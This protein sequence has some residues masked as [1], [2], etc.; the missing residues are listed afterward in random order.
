[1]QRFPKLKFFHFT[2]IRVRYLRN[3]GFEQTQDWK[4]RNVCLYGLCY[5]DGNGLSFVVYLVQDYYSGNYWNFVI[6]EFIVTDTN[7]R[8]ISGHSHRFSAISWKVF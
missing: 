5:S 8:C 4:G 3:I 1:M 6:F 7:D 2:Y